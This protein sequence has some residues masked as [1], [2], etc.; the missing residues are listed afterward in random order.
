MAIG[1]YHS[2]L[3]ASGCNHVETINGS[4]SECK[5]RNDCNGGSDVYSWG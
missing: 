3:I 1:D 4:T 2:V 5:G